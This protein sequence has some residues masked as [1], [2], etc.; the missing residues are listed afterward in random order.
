MRQ[1][2]LGA[3][4]RV[5]WKRPFAAGMSY[6]C[7]MQ[8]PDA[9]DNLLFNSKN[10]FGAATPKVQTAYCIHQLE[11]KVNNGGFHQYFFN[12]SGEYVRETLRAFAAIGAVTTCAL[13]Q[14]AVAI[15][16]P[17]GYPADSQQRQECLADFDD[18][19]DALNP[20]DSAFLKYS[21]PLAD[22]VNDYLSVRH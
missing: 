15:G 7:L 2:R 5:A 11:S 4:E 6:I 18:I 13:L 3:P 10:E 14:R 21:E 20:L 9:F 19:A 16:F 17:D 22:L 12:S 8:Y 1:R